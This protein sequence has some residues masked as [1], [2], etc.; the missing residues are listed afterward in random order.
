MKNVILAIVVVFILVLA[1]YFGYVAI[2]KHI[3]QKSGVIVERVLSDNTI[4]QLK[5]LSEIQLLVK[6][7]NTELA[8]AKIL[9]ATDTFKYILKNNCDT[10][11][12]KEALHKYASPSKL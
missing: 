3:D 6:A 11:K 5:L 7:K 2:N 9:E 4:A 12:C 1:S 8:N 10:V